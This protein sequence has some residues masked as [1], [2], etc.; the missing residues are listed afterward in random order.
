MAIRLPQ[1]CDFRHQHI[2]FAFIDGEGTQPPSGSHRYVKLIRDQ[3][4]FDEYEAVDDWVFTEA[5][6]LWQA[7]YGDM[8]DEAALCGAWAD[9]LCPGTIPY[10]GP[11]PLTPVEQATIYE[12][13]SGSRCDLTM[14]MLYLMIEGLG[15]RPGA[16]REESQPWP[17]QQEMLEF[18]NFYPRE[19][20]PEG[21]LQIALSLLAAGPDGETQRPWNA[22][23]KLIRDVAALAENEQVGTP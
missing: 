13:V 6:P 23:D 21:A 11:T 20:D 17:S 12:F 1:G 19:H 16:C 14:G 22:I 8:V 4:P 2:V 10:D 9:T 18:Y 5:P 15:W 3:D 7:K